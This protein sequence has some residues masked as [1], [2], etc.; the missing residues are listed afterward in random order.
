M[1]EDDSI[2]EDEDIVISFD[3]KSYAYRESKQEQITTTLCDNS[4]L[5]N[6]QP[7]PP[8]LSDTLATTTTIDSNTQTQENIIR[9]MNDI[10]SSIP[11]INNLQLSDAPMDFDNTW[12]LTTFTEEVLDESRVSVY[13]HQPHLEQQQQQETLQ[14]TNLSLS[15]P[16]EMSLTDLYLH[17]LG[18][19]KERVESIIRSH[20]QFID[21]IKGHSYEI[22]HIRHFLINEVLHLKQQEEET[23]FM[24]HA[25]IDVNISNNMLD[26]NFVNL[27]YGFVS[28][29]VYVAKMESSLNAHKINLLIGQLDTFLI[30]LHH[31]LSS[32]VNEKQ[33]YYHYN[34]QS[35]TNHYIIHPLLKHKVSITALT[36]CPYPIIVSRDRSS[37]RELKEE[38]GCA[39]VDLF[40]LKTP[41]SKID[42]FPYHEENEFSFLKR[43]IGDDSS[44]DSADNDASVLSSFTSDTTT[45]TTLERNCV[46][47]EVN[48]DPARNSHLINNTRTKKSK[49]RTDSMTKNP[50]FNSIPSTPVTP[51]NSNNFFMSDTPSTSFHFLSNSASS[52]LQTAHF[53][54]GVSSPPYEIDSVIKNN[55][56]SSPILKEK[57]INNNNNTTETSNMV[58]SATKYLP[59]FINSCELKGVDIYFQYKCTQPDI[60]VFVDGTCISDNNNNNFRNDISKTTAECPVPFY[61]TSNKSQIPDLLKI[62]YGLEIIHYYENVVVRYQQQCIQNEIAAYQQNFPRGTQPFIPIDQHRLNNLTLFNKILRFT[63]YFIVLLT[64]QNLRNPKRYLSETEY[65]FIFCNFFSSLSPE[66][67]YSSNLE[68][69]EIND[70]SSFDFNI[71]KLNRYWEWISTFIFLIKFRINKKLENT[72][73]ILWFNNYIMH[74]DF[75]SKYEMIL[76]KDGNVAGDFLLRFCEMNRG[77]IDIAVLRKRDITTNN[78]NNNNNNNSQTQQ[79]YYID[80]IIFDAEKENYEGLIWFI[81]KIHYLKN[82]IYYDPESKSYLKSAKD[83]LFIKFPE[84][85]SH[86][87]ENKRNYMG[88]YKN[89]VASWGISEINNGDE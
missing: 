16:T 44:S 63:Q 54:S 2:V 88:N 27:N 89:R 80:H 71:E 68:K 32:D 24:L 11:E 23:R 86:K 19:C 76:K 28:Q 55:I 78:N 42:A 45:T 31:F 67:Y 75:A 83:Q 49:K 39:V 14:I 21:K 8:S 73:Y 4:S 46:T 6:D 3:G 69:L 52:D 22:Q 29:N 65:K 77:C 33:K 9:P 30:N 81:M 37:E 36:L 10:T 64:Y 72:I 47:I 62:F 12:N 40:L 82:I 61:I 15:T 18:E 66:K 25:F 79:Q 85:K 50:K 53:N 43:I 58:F 56:I 57:S 35:S 51:F 34:T 26:V 7:T 17:K 74:F 1:E 87:Q 38:K 13:S 59:H 5:P 70:K 20:Q 60:E 41:Y 48:F 84:L